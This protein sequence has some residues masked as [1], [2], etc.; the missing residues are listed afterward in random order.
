MLGSRTPTS[1]LQEQLSNLA[2]TLPAIR[3]G[4]DKAIHDARVATRRLRETLALVA[5]YTE[6]EVGGIGDVVR[7]FGRALGKARDVAIVL[8]LI[9]DFRRRVPIAV[10]VLG[11]ME[12]SVARARR[13]SLRELIKEME[14]CEVEKLQQHAGR[15]LRR[16]HFLLS[17][18]TNH[19]RHALRAHISERAHDL[20]AAMHH[21]TGVYFPNRSHSTRIAVKK[22]RYPLELASDT[23]VW[24][25]PR[26][27]KR[28]KKVQEDLGRAHDLQVLLDRVRELERSAATS[29]GIDALVATLEAEIQE[30][31]ARYTVRRLSLEAICDACD[32]LSH[33][34]VPRAVIAATATASVAIPALVLV[35]RWSAGARS[36]HT[37][38][39]AL[40]MASAQ[41]RRSPG[42]T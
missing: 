17:R 3:D 28:L 8:E 36:E 40:S 42:V 1:I 18:R 13:D 9:A 27:M 16:S 24:K 25:A 31:Y 12:V 39:P 10:G 22:L 5:A 37:S 33:R 41:R 38:A 4:D 29:D 23:G 7:R 15:L 21:A 6:A 26:A 34:R 20:R 30:L 11:A 19:W 35:H 2:A 32:R 14:N